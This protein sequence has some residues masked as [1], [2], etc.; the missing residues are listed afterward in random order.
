MR[1]SIVQ[2]NQPLLTCRFIL[3]SCLAVSPWRV[4]VLFG[5]GTMLHHPPPGKIQ[6]AAFRKAAQAAA[7][8]ISEHE[9]KLLEICRLPP[10]EA[11]RRYPRLTR[12]QLAAKLK[13]SESL[14]YKKLRQY[15]ITEAE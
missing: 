4:T 12:G 7:N 10:E 13:I 1:G 2:A 15:G 14:L 11:L 5:H 3:N 8:V 6:H 9:Q